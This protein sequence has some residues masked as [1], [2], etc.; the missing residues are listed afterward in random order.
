M[1]LTVRSIIGNGG[2]RGARVIAGEKGLNNLVT[3]ISVLEVGE[4]NVKR[5]VLQN[6]VYLTAFYAIRHDVQMQKTV[7]KAIVSSGCSALI[8]CHLG[9][10]VKEISN[11]VIEL[12]NSLDFPLIIARPEVSYI[13]IMKPIL[14]DLILKSDKE[15]QSTKHFTEIRND[16][17]ELVINENDYYIIFN[18]ISQQLR[19]KATYLD[20]YYNCVY[21]D[22]LKKQ[23]N[24]EIRY[25][26]VNFGQLN[27]YYSQGSPFIWSTGSCQKAIFPIK[28]MRNFFG[29]LIL[30]LNKEL[31]M[32]NQQYL[33]EIVTSISTICTIIFSRKNKLEE[34]Q[35]RYLREYITDLL[36][37]N[38][39]TEDTAV[40][41]GLEAGLDIRNKHNI[42]IININPRENLDSNSSFNIRTS[43]KNTYLPQINEMIN[44]WDKH[45]SIIH[46]SETIIIFFENTNN[47]KDFKKIGQNITSLFEHEENF[48]VSIGISDHFSNIR[49][50]PTAYTQAYNASILGRSLFGENRV[51]TYLEIWLFEHLQQLSREE[52]SKDMCHRLLAPLIEYDEQ[53]QTCLLETLSALISCN[54]NIITAANKLFIHRNTLLYRKN[55]IIELLGYSPFEMPHV[56]NVFI[57]LKTLNGVAMI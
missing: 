50:I 44:F 23:V 43:I 25:I 12:C 35:E 37:W 34:M 24:E 14:R 10:W 28:S 16:L 52:S 53:H 56:F 30:D 36:V 5:W 1:A 18:K 46:R 47:D 51:T 31:N 2:L 8:I 13:D 15:I 9:M 55:K 40:R 48:S 17:L 32:Q 20:I 11:E 42:M 49:S 45:S 21:S 57:A 27:Q 33:N 39:S 41:Q 29:F 19:I 22:K 54:G 6:Q 3:S 38:F 4:E 26:Q 7:I